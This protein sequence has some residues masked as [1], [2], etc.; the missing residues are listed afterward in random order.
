MAKRVLVVDDDPDLREAAQIILSNAG[1]EVSQAS[2]AGEAMAKLEEK[3]VDLVLLDV[4]MESDTAGFHLAY[5]IREKDGLRDLPIVMLTSIEEKT[6][7]SLEAENSG[8]YLPV[9]GFL[10]K[11]LDPKELKAKL[12]SLL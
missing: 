11:P 7:V 4:M 1:Y 12:E 8:D 2:S 9:Q 5:K 6:G 10:R 3:P